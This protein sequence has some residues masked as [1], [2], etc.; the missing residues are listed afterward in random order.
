MGPYSATLVGLVLLPP[1]DKFGLG[2]LVT[3][4]TASLSLLSKST[5]GIRGALAIVFAMLLASP[6][7]PQN[8]RGT[9]RGTGQDATDARI[10]LSEDSYSPAPPSSV[11][12]SAKTV[13]NFASMTNRHHSGGECA[14]L[15]YYKRH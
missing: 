15:H 14:P 3:A 2:S 4:A 12:P 11:N 6:L 5:K 1:R 9:L 13:E 10:S 7:H 8:P